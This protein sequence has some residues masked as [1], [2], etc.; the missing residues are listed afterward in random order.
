MITLTKAEEAVMN[1]LWELEEAKL[2]EI[3]EKMPKPPPHK[4]TVATV[5]K[6]LVSKK[7]V[8]VHGTDRVFQYRPAIAKTEYF[9]ST[10]DKLTHN[11]FKGSF[12]GMVSFLVN[13]RNLTVSDLEMLINELKENKEKP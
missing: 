6:V 1:V 11:Y 12:K 13:E 10:L 2:M 9:K 7:F 3:V 8:T 4:N 5:L